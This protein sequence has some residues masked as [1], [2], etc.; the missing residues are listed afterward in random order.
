MGFGIS[1]YGQLLDQVSSKSADPHVQTLEHFPRQWHLKE[2]RNASLTAHSFSHED[3]DDDDD[4]SGDYPYDYD[5]FWDEEEYREFDDPA[6]KEPRF[7]NSEKIA[8]FMAEKN[9]S[10]LSKMG[11]SFEDMVLSCTYRGVPCQ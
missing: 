6:K 8:V 4:N 5:D 10:F 1:Q 9:E 7:L 11:H 2:S 3:D